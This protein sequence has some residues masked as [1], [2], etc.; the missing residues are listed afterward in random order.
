MISFSISLTTGKHYN[1]NEYPTKTLKYCVDKYVLP[2]N[3]KTKVKSVLS[4]GNKMDI[5]KTL[6]ENNIAQGD[7]VVVCVDVE[8]EVSSSNNTSFSTTQINK[9]PS[10]ANQNN[11]K[12]NDFN[13]CLNFIVNACKVPI[14]MLDRHGNCYLDWRKGGKNGPPGY[15]KNYFPPLG[16]YGIGL[17]VWNLYDNGKNTWLSNSNQQG[18]W[19]V[20][21]HP[22]KSIESIIGILN[23]GFRRGPF[24]DCKHNQ[25]VNPLTNG[26][27]PECGEGV[28]F[29]P[30]FPEINLFAKSFNYLGDIFKVA[31]M[32]R[33]NPYKVRICTQFLQE[34]WIVNGDLLGD[35]NGRKRDDEVR[36]CRIL[37]FI[38]K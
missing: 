6:S 15:L 27:Y 18:E 4:N 24:Q 2:Q 30:F 34:S 12:Y 21:Y 14:N 25:N 33:I 29:I 16:W 36:P 1:I 10:M 13:K 11:I 5:N 35:P 23:G 20:A 31:L 9:F 8:T 22:I 28:Y 37:V 3:P 7:T 26:L 38:G 19:Y 17:K 32:C